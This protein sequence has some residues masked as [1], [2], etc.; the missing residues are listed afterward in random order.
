MLLCLT[1]CGTLSSPTTVYKVERDLPPAQLLAPCPIPAEPKGHS[2]GDLALWG[3]ETRES[4]Q[5]CDAD[6]AAL[7]DWATKK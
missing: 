6:K 2:N 3:N 1:A 5:S 4:L 7:R